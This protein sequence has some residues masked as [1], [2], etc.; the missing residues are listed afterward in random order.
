MEANWIS[1]SVAQMLQF[2][3]QQLSVRVTNVRLAAELPSKNISLAYS[4]YVSSCR[5]KTYLKI[6]LQTQMISYIQ[7]HMLDQLPTC[8]Q[9]IAIRHSHYSQIG[10]Q[11]W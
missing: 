4:K 6:L 8:I 11:Q 2:L 5:K 10:H 3:S 7:L 1:E 9:N